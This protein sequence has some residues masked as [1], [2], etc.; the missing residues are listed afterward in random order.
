MRMAMTAALA[1]LM[2]IWAAG[3]D[4]GG[5]PGIDALANWVH[6]Q[7][8]FDTAPLTRT[9]SFLGE[10]LA[11]ISAVGGKVVVDVIGRAN[12]PQ[13]NLLV[14]PPWTERDGELLWVLCRHVAGSAT[15]PVTPELARELMSSGRTI[16][17]QLFAGSLQFGYVDGVYMAQIRRF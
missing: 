7:E 14:T 9:K 12:G 4:A 6:R 3:I 16:E 2:L 13:V 8:P 5:K 1:A 10:P 11:R 17:V 15:D